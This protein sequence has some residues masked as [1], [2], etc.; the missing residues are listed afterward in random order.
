[1]ALEVAGSIPVTHPIKFLGRRLCLKAFYT[2]RLELGP[3]AQLAEHAPFKRGVDGSNPS[4]PTK[5]F[6][7]VAELADAWDLGSH[8]RP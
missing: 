3:L 4:W 1:M 6:A 2:K 8:G 7:G 5:I